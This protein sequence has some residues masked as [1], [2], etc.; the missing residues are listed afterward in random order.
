[1]TGSTSKGRSRAAAPVHG[2]RRPVQAAVRSPGQWVRFLLGWAVLLAVLLGTSEIDASGRFG[3]AILAVVVLA[4]VAVE[5]LL[6]RV[7]PREALRSLGFGRT[8]GRALVAAFVVGG[9]VQF[10]F[11]VTETITGTTFNLRPD[12][13]ILLIGIFA[14]HGLAEE[15]VWRGY[16]YRRLR[17]GR[18]FWAAV[19]WTMPLVAVAHVPIVI[20]SGPLVGAAALLVA[21]ATSVPLAYLFDTGRRTIWAPAVVHTAIDSFK[22]V[23]IP[24]AALTTFSLLLAAFSIVVPLLVLAVPRRIL[25]TSRQT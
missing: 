23:V 14:F 13:P 4:G 6:Y 17:V 21:A 5:Y 20:T 1:M 16:A 9:L 7:G 25:Q 10:V 2:D 22:I 15:L 3:L 24:A 12:W 19:L 11:P 18:P 8:G